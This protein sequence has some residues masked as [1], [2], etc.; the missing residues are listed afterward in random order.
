MEE[1]LN[2]KTN[3]VVI[4]GAPCSGKTTIIQRLESKGYHVAHEV[5]RAYISDLLREDP[6]HPKLN[7]DSHM[8]DKILSLKRAREKFLNPKDKVFFDR[9]VPDSLAYYRLYQLDEAVVRDKLHRFIYKAVFYLDP[10]PL[11]KDDIRKEDEATAKE[12]GELIQ[13]G[14]TELGYSLIHVPVLPIQERLA[15]ILDKLS[16]VPDCL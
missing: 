11:V 10:L 6:Q 8:Q 2:R 12:I 9:G 16:E 15:F 13:Q 5:A 1:I 3:W 14:Y 7:H 4:T